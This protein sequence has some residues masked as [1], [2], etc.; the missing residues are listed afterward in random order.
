MSLVLTMVALLLS[1]VAGYNDY[2]PLWEVDPS[3]PVEHQVIKMT[4]EMY[5]EMI[6]ERYWRKSRNDV[7]WVIAFYKHFPT[8]EEATSKGVMNKLAELYRGK[9]RF[10]WVD[11]DEEELLAASFEAMYPPQAFLIKDGMTYW[12]RDFHTVEMMTI[13]IETQKYF[14]STTRFPQPSRFHEAQL[15]TYTYIKK[16]IRYVYKEH[17]EVPLRRFM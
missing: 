6:T 9:I 10:A 17:I 5:D 11:K 2:D 7:P 16:E 4:G 14:N 13:Y 1:T 8:S 3:M 12:Y 15:Y